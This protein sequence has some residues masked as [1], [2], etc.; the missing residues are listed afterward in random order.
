M[1]VIA[2]I[3]AI[4]G[5]AGLVFGILYITQAS[6]ADK[7]IADS[8]APLTLDQVDAKYNTISANYN[9]YKADEEPQIQAGKAAPSV[10]YD[11]LSA[12]RALLGLARANIGT[13]TFVRTSGIVDIIMGLGLILAGIAL[14]R[15]SQSAA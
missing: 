4:L 9:K 14:F 11:Y 5:L 6:A 1:R 10:M 3:V 2:I 8:V 13:A 12:Q 15:K 7:E